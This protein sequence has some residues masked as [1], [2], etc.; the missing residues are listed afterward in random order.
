MVQKSKVYN[1]SGIGLCVFTGA[2][3]NKVKASCKIQCTIWVG[4]K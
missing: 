2:K 3:Y 1:R 4:A